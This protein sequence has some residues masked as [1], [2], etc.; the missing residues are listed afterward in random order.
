MKGAAGAKSK[1][2]V[3]ESK[4]SWM[5]IFWLILAFVIGAAIFAFVS[6]GRGKDAARKFKRTFQ[7]MTGG[8]TGKR[9]HKD[10]Q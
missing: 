2:A 9:N 5:G 3:Q 6:T 8:L 7:E 4:G 10:P 1:A